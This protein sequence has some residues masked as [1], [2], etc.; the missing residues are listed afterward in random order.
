MRIEYMKKGLLFLALMLPMMASAREVTIA[1]PNG[2]LVVTVND[3]GGK[4]TYCVSLDGKQMVTKS[5][6]GLN[7]SLGDLTKDLKI[8]SNTIEVVEKNYDI[9]T[10]KTSHI[11]YKA[12]KLLLTLENQQKQQMKSIKK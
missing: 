3:E 1:S 9:H 4:A 7:T 5:N 6:L 10:I 8:V 11:D 12:N 2:K